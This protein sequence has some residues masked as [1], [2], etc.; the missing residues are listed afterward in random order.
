ME[1]LAAESADPEKY[2]QIRW[3]RS[4]ANACQEMPTVENPFNRK[5]PVGGSGD[6]ASKLMDGTA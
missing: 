6:Q 4:R 3:E 1:G 2:D 5:A